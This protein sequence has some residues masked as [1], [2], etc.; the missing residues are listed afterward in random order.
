LN[1]DRVR[2]DNITMKSF[3]LLPG[4]V[5]LATGFAVSTSAQEI[6]SAYTKHDY[7]TCRHLP[8]P[9]PDVIDLRECDGFGGWK[10]RWGGGPDET[11]IDFSEVETAQDLKLGSFFVVGSTIEWRGPVV[12]KQINPQTAIVRYH[13]GA[14]IESQ[15]H[16]S[17]VIYRL[18]GVPCAVSTLPGSTP[19]A[20]E[21]AR[22]TA[23]ETGADTP[24]Y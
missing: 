6:A 21:V 1:P 3:C 9:E 10:F 18:S 7:E 19:K 17:L 5:L 12:N 2:S 20:N 11:W 13:T 23:D 24:C 4:V 15:P 14:S 16:S 8:S 22:M